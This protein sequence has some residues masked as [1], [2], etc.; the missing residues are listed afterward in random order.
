MQITRVMGGLHTRVIAARRAEQAPW[1]WLSQSLVYLCMLRGGLY[2]CTGHLFRL[3]LIDF[4]NAFDLSAKGFVLMVFVS[5]VY[6]VYC[7]YP[8]DT[9]SSP[10][11]IFIIMHQ[12][13]F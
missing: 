13:I 7:G 11:Q 4:H 3:L 10:F 9:S 8:G 5:H 2:L 1:K 6:P 12:L